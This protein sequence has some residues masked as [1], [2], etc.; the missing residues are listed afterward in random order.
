MRLS[1]LQRSG[2]VGHLYIPQSKGLS[3]F[4]GVWSDRE[5][6]VGQSPCTSLPLLVSSLIVE[7]CK[8]EQTWI[9]DLEKSSSD[10]SCFMISNNYYL[11]MSVGMLDEDKRD[12]GMRKGQMLSLGW[13][14]AENSLTVIQNV[15][16]AHLLPPLLGSGIGQQLSWVSCIFC[17]YAEVLGWRKGSWCRHTPAVTGKRRIGI[18]GCRCQ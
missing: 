10:F 8:M 15:K 2:V 1:F 17:D 18:Q 12:Y 16:P 5:G 9:E 4:S 14:G 13:G 11:Q 6:K 7:A 3:M